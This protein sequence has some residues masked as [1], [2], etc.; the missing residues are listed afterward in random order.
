ML[1]FGISCG[2]AATPSTTP[3]EVTAMAP[4]SGAVLLDAGENKMVD[5][6]VPLG[7]VKQDVGGRMVPEQGRRV[8]GMAR[9]SV[10]QINARIP[11]GDSQ[12][13]V[14]ANWTRAHPDASLLFQ[15]SG[16]ECGQSSLWAGEVMRAAQ[17]FGNDRSQF[18]YVHLSQSKQ[19]VTILYGSAR[20]NGRSYYGEQNIVLDQPWAGAVTP[21]A[22][23]VNA[24]QAQRWQV[25]VFRDGKG[26]T[27][28][29][30][31]TLDL[32]QAI[33]GIKQSGTMHW[34]VIADACDV[35]DAPAAF[36]QSASALS[37]GVD[38]LKAAIPA[39]KILHEVNVGNSTASRCNG[40]GGIE[41]V[42][43][44]P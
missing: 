15:C 31:L 24:V 29:R 5:Q 28:T 20:A 9:R 21:K 7:Y 12:N 4:I 16:R 37:A 30:K 41:I 2:Y 35:R 26:N 23:G 17:L 43:L 27:D 42:E 39:D 1:M 13:E 11:L 22:S 14:I 10:Y 36:S 25:E 34:A 38:V 44:Y 32:A 19:V 40:R 3:S 8:S 18:A 33:G 6:W